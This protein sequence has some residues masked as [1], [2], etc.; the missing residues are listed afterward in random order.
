MKTL[1]KK[2]VCCLIYILLVIKPSSSKEIILFSDLIPIN[3]S[4]SIVKFQLETF[5]ASYPQV[6]FINDYSSSQ[7]KLEK[8]NKLQAGFI[9]G[10]KLKISA[11]LSIYQ[12]NHIKNT[13]PTKRS[14]SLIS[15]DT[16]LLNRD[17]GPLKISKWRPYIGLKYNTVI[18][19]K[20]NCFEG[21]NFVVGGSEGE[22]KVN[23]K[24]FYDS[25]QNGENHPAIIISSNSIG[26]KTGVERFNQSWDQKNTIRLGIE[27]LVSDYKVIKGNGFNSI[28][29]N[30]LNELPQENPFTSNI[31]SASFASARKL[32]E[33]WAIGS[34]LRLFHVY[35][36]SFD[37]SSLDRNYKNNLIFDILLSRKSKTN[38]FIGFGLMYSTNFT[39]GIEGNI[40]NQETYKLFGKEYSQIS[41]S[42]GWLIPVSEKNKYIYDKNEILKSLYKNQKSQKRKKEIKK[43][44]REKSSEKDFELVSKKIKDESFYNHALNFAVSYDRGIKN[45]EVLISLK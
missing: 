31:I 2:I 40:Y 22:C 5:N 24:S 43:L 37:S 6:Q 42:Y 34:G 16:S 32:G 28:N 44:K 11:D 39:N 29:G 18:S 45:T 14:P 41:F 36:S 9:T 1:I 20:V 17:D 13:Y 23:G 26:L 15:I 12:Q 30:L 3:P 19:D 33:K 8:S 21:A 10:N 27:H 4:E 7:V 35:R 25:N 38:S